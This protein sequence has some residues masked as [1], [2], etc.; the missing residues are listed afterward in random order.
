M[1]TPLRE[2]SEI[3]LWKARIISKLSQA[4]DC[5]DAM[6]PTPTNRQPNTCILTWTWHG[7]RQWW[8][9]HQHHPCQPPQWACHDDLYQLGTIHQRCMTNSQWCPPRSLVLVATSHHPRNSPL[10][11]MIADFLL[12]AVTTGHEETRLL[13]THAML[14]NT[15]SLINKM[16]MILCNRL[17]H[18]PRWWIPAT[19]LQQATSYLSQACSN[20]VQQQKNWGNERPRVTWPG[21]GLL[22]VGWYFCAILHGHVVTFYD[23]VGVD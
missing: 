22:F 14:G 3:S 1:W 21:N 13:S 16:T 19:S 4:S 10:Q 17:C 6:M 5:H 12:L 20:R 8:N 2:S 18:E 15:I 23:G 7:N 9:H 11:T